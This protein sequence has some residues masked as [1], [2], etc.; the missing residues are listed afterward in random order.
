MWSARPAKTTPPSWLRRRLPHA[1]LLILP[2]GFA[3]CCMNRDRRSSGSCCSP[4]RFRGEAPFQSAPAGADID[5]RHREH[6]GLEACR[7]SVFLSEWT[8]CTQPV[9]CQP[10]S[11]GRSHYLAVLPPNASASF[12]IPSARSEGMSAQTGLPST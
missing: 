4:N 10:F 6:V 11:V 12:F 1:G 9:T 5:G 3:R 8:D 2:T 7:R